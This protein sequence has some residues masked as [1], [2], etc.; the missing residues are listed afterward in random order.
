MFVI[1]HNRAFVPLRFLAFFSLAMDYVFV[2]V[3][4]CD[5]AEVTSLYLLLILYQPVR[6]IWLLIHT[7]QHLPNSEISTQIRTLSL[8]VVSCRWLKK[9]LQ[10]GQLQ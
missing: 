5:L 9:M 8:L 4:V 7:I 3:C 6:S 1:W 2:C 10:V